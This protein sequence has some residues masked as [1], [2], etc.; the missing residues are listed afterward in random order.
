MPHASLPALGVPSSN[1]WAAV[2]TRARSMWPEPTPAGATRCDASLL[3]CWVRLY[4]VDQP[5][6]RACVQA[7]A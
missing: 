2:A 1:D 4:E 5:R 6:P 3:T 7:R